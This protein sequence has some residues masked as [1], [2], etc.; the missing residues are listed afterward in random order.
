MFA[1]IFVAMYVQRGNPPSIY[2]CMALMAFS[3]QRAGFAEQKFF[4]LRE[5]R[6]RK[7]PESHSQGFNA[8]P[9]LCCP[10]SSLILSFSFLIEISLNKIYNSVCVYL[11]CAS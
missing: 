8:L 4:L 3:H 2:I 6:L 5:I 10:P 9:A 11:Q 1:C 7:E